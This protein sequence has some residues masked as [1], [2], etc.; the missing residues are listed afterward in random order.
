MRTDNWKLTYDNVLQ[1]PRGVELY[2]LVNDPGERDNLIDHP[3]HA[4]KVE[5]LTTLLETTMTDH[6]PIQ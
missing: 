3:D 4:A 2:D 5:E 6:P 1:N